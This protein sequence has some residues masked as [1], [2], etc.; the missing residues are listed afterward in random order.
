MKTKR[1]GGALVPL[2]L[3]AAM[4]LGGC[5]TRRAINEA[6]ATENPARADEVT[7]PPPIRPEALAIVQPTAATEA[8]T[9]AARPLSRDGRDFTR[10]GCRRASGRDQ[11]PRNYDR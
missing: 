4:T 11:W 1:A 9:I 2:V 10:G 8:P 6:L 5:A 3:L 7:G